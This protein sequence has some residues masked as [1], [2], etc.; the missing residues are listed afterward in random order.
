MP[1]LTRR[2]FLGSIGAGLA[3]P[4]LPA[5]T[6][7]AAPVAHTR[8]QF[9]WASYYAQMNNACSP[10]H[11]IRALG[12]SP[13]VAES[14]YRALLARDVLRIPL[15]G[16]IARARQPMAAGM[17]GHRPTM[18]L[19]KAITQHVRVNLDWVMEQVTR[20]ISNQIPFQTNAA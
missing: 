17:T 4:I 2:F 5:T 10:H 7:A 9:V 20:D 15:S 1:R 16:G 13:A 11:I 8:L 6:A 18:R 14:L 3:A 12:V 19:R